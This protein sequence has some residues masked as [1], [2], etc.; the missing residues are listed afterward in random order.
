PKLRLGQVHER[1]GRNGEALRCYQLAAIVAPQEPEP[2]LHQVF[3]LVAMERHTEARAVA[4]SLGRLNGTANAPALAAIAAGVVASADGNA[5][6]AVTH[7][8]AAVRKSGEHGTYALC[9]LA[10]QLTDLGRFDEASEAYS[11]ALLL[12][13]GNLRAHMGLGYLNYRRG[14]LSAAGD[15]FKTAYE[16][17]KDQ[18]ERNAAEPA[19]FRGVVAEERGRL[20]VAL[21]HYRAAVEHDPEALDFRLALAGLYERMEQSD[22]ALRIYLDVSRLDSSDALCVLQA[23]LILSERKTGARRALELVEEAVRRDAKLHDAYLVGGSICQDV[24]SQPKAA[25]RWYERYLAAGGRDRRV[26]EWLR[27]L[28]R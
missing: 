1:A 14:D 12:E 15:R 16:R 5:A 25:I 7:F 26:R 4:A 20:R 24:L 13:S 10:D 22:R 18:G 8:R 28:R 21:K 3:S 9:L 23:A 19:Y 27:E 2:L 11:R 17:A 6:G